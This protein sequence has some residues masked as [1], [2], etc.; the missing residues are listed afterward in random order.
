MLWTYTYIHTYIH[1]L[2][3]IFKKRKT[4]ENKKQENKIK[5]LLRRTTETIKAFAIVDAITRVL[6]TLRKKMFHPKCNKKYHFISK[7]PDRTCYFIRKLKLNSNLVC[8]RFERSAMYTK[9]KG[10]TLK[11]CPIRYSTSNLMDSDKIKQKL[12]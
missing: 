9:V 7:G 3:D 1:I 10:T 6:N 4:K 11:K 2:R 5:F 12:P 8:V